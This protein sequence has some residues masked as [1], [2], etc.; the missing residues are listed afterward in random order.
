M[1]STRS[2][3]TAPTAPTPPRRRGE[4]VFLKRSALPDD[5]D[6]RRLEKKGRW[7]LVLSY[8]LCPCHLPI[9]LTLLG[10]AFGGT[11]LGSIIAGN[12]GWVAVVMVALYAAVLA[13]GFTHLRRAKRLLAPGQRLSCTPDACEIVDAPTA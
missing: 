12:A 4:W 5:P 10:L 6:A 11:A 3:E 9:T 1:T 2:L 13:R 7:W 8:V